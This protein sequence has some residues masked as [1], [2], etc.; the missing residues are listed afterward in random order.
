MH[1]NSNHSKFYKKV[2]YFILRTLQISLRNPKDTTTFTN[3]KWKAKYS[4]EKI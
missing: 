2:L 3:R 1:L 4:R